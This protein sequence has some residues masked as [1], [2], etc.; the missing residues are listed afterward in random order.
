VSDIKVVDIKRDCEP[1]VSQVA[2]NLRSHLRQG[3]RHYKPSWEECW[4]INTCQRY[5]PELL[6]FGVSYTITPGGSCLV[7]EVRT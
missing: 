1:L 2:E 4:A 7:I 6:S 5:W 3:V